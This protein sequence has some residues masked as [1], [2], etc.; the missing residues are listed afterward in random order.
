MYL[1]LRAPADM[2]ALRHAFQGIRDWEVLRD[3]APTLPLWRL[4]RGDLR[5]FAR[6]ISCH[7]DIAADGAFSL[8]MLAR[9]EPVLRE[10]GASAWREL[11]WE[12][13][14]IGQSL[15]LAAEAAGVRGTGIGCYF[16]DELHR[17]LGLKGHDWQSLYHFT[18]GNPVEDLRLR[19]V[20][21]YAHLKT[22][23]RGL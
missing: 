16:D 18:I 13:G 17:A 8:G 15:Y 1:W 20:H 12:A 23:A 4:D 2:E 3:T 5:D 9:F 7:Q 21:P 11:F 14:M 22:G 6:A 19:T 10:R